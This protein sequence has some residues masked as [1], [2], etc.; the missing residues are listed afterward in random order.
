MERTM[1]L[2]LAIL[3]AVPL[4]AADRPRVFVT[5]SKSW[6]ISGG[7]GAGSNSAAGVVQGGARPQT[8]EV[9]KTFG[10]RCPEVAVTMKQE[11]ADYI[12]LLDHEGGK[13]VVRRDNKVAVFNEDGEMVHSGSTRTLGNAVKD[14]CEAIKNDR[15]SKE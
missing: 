10:E 3:C 12:V 7:F 8:A 5:D 11:K 4:V 9:M 14:A 1:L 6:E 15:K 2:L 13:G